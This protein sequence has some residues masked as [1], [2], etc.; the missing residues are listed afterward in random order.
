VE[1]E[2]L[3]EKKTIHRRQE[4]RFKQ[5]YNDK[6]TVSSVIFAICSA[7]TSASLARVASRVRFCASRSATSASNFSFS[8]SKFY[9]DAKQEKQ[10]QNGGH[11]AIECNNKA[12][13]E[14]LKKT[15]EESYAV[16]GKE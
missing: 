4:E 9:E 10:Q 12:G 5:A 16:D 15:L 6:F 8:A 2:K 14:T 1:R 13:K 7:L 11:V 3:H